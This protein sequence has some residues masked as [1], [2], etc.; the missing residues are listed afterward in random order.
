MHIKSLVSV[1]ALTAALAFS[2]PAFAQTMVGGVS[3]SEDDM[4]RVTTYCEELSTAA[5]TEPAGDDDGMEDDGAN[6]S[7]SEQ[8]PNGTDQALTTLDLS[9]I[10]LEG[11]TEAGIVTE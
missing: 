8:A 2:A 4:A 7:E 9:T 10:T 6:N 11:C 5:L 1:A 3:V